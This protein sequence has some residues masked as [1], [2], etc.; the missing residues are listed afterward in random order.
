MVSSIIIISWNTHDLLNQCLTSVFKTPLTDWEIL[1]VD[2]ASTDGSSPMVREHFPK[3]QLIENKENVGFAS[4][5]NQAIRK[6]MGK[7]ILLLNSDTVVKPNALQEMVRFMDEHPETGAAGAYLLNPDGTLQP[8]CEPFPTLT[9]EFLRLFHLTSLWQGNCY[10]MAKWDPKKP[11]EVEVIKGACLILRKEALKTIGLLDED[12]F[13]YSEDV[14][15]CYRLRKAGWHLYWV[16]TAKVVH[17]GGQS[18]HLVAAESFIRLYEGK[19][20]YI[21]KHHGRPAGAVYKMILLAA[22]LSRLVLVPFTFFEQPAARKQHLTIANHYRR[23]LTTL[24]GM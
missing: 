2:N 1:L 12:F 18:S 17:Y 9:R 24:P 16:P 23:L 22:S 13:F 5:N 14:D 4:A 3:V 7:L 10:R 8:S 15:L 20:Q 11:R 19:L 21:R 6:S